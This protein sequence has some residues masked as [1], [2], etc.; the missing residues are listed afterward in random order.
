MPPEVGQS[1]WIAWYL[2]RLAVAHARV[3]DPE[4]ACSVAAQA[5][6][7]TRQ[8]QS[9]RL[10]AQ[11]DRLLARLSA[12]WPTLPAVVGLSELMS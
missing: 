10:R 9:S 8:T 6:L 5:A 11:L 12:R 2:V 3:G 1:E 4:Q 7:I